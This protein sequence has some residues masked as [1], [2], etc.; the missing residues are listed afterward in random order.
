MLVFV[1]A[2]NVGRLNVDV[3]YLVLSV[4]KVEKVFHMDVTDYYKF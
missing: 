2:L 4:G 3:V 1:T